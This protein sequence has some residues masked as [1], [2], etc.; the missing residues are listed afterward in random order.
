MFLKIVDIFLV[1][2]I[3]D[4]DQKILSHIIFIRES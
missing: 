3:V 2:I 1:T 4:L